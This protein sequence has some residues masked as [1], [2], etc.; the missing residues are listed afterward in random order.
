MGFSMETSISI[1][2]VWIQGALSFFSPCVLPLVPLYLGYLAGGTANAEWSDQKRRKVTLRNTVFF[3]LGISAAFFM[4]G[5]G[6]TALGN[7]LNGNR[8][9]ITRVGGILIFLLGLYQI[10][11]VKFDFLQK[12]RRLPFRFERVGMNPITAFLLG[13]VFSFAWTPCVGPALTSVLLLAGSAASRGVGF[14]LIGV[15]TLGFVLPFLAVGLFTSQLLSFFRKHS[16][17]LRYTAKLGGLLLMFMGIMMFTGWMN[18]ITGYLSGVGAGS[19]ITTTSQTTSETQ[20]TTEGQAESEAAEPQSDTIPAPDFTLVDQ[21]GN[22]HTLSDYKGKVVFLNFWAT[23]CGPCKQEMPDIEQ[24]YLDEGANL[25]DVI[26]LGVAAPKSDDNPFNQETKDIAGITEF[27]EQGGYTYP[28]LMDTTGDVLNAY[29]IQAFPT[30]FMIDADGNLF[31]YLT[32]T[33][34][35]EIMDSIIEQTKTG[36]RTGV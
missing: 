8:L 15:Y 22:T 4:L 23:W 11:F 32:G 18:Q 17:W 21:Y 12:E 33:M 5:L 27:L 29:G 10:G 7:L 6:F 1:L 13:F 28:V 20:Q 26:I 14:L 30:T 16:N 9:W 19:G 3:V 24:L 34:T 31:G 36:V 25:E 2:T 35:R